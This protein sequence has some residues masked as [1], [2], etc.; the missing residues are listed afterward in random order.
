MKTKTK[1]EDMRRLTDERVSP[2]PCFEEYIRIQN[3]NK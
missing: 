1:H 2:H 3:E